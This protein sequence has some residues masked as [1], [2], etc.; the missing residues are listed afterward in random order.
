MSAVLC[1]VSLGSNLSDPALQ[2]QRAIETFAQSPQLQIKKI[3]SIYQ[4]KPIGPVQQDDFLNAVISFTT[5][6]TPDELLGFLQQLEAKHQ[7]L[8]AIKWGPRTLDCDLLLYGNKHIDLPH[9]TVPHP[10][11]KNRGFVLIPLAEIAPDLILPNGDLL[12]QW[13]ENC[14]AKIVKK[15]PTQ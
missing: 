13:V 2:L 11:M 5:L 1:F 4:T 9:L 10:E 14:D 3:S 7:R 6:L 15:L 8:R 12:Q